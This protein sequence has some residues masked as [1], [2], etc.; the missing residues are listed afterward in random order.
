MGFK[1]GKDVP[2]MEREL[3][4]LLYDLCVKWG[5]C[6]PPNDFEQISKKKY[7]HA[8][9]FAIDVVKAEGMEGYTNWTNRITERFK[10]RFG[11]EEIDSKS[12]VDRVRGI[13]ENW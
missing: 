4:Y 8:E 12:F 1:V 7:Y 9:D 3:I 13:K 2:P 11:S 10:E 5:F 6:I